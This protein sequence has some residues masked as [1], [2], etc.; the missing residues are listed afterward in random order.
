MYC[1]ACG[2]LNAPNATI[3]VKCGRAMHAVAPAAPAAVPVTTGRVERHIQAMGILWL[4]YALMGAVGWFIAIPFI[5]GFFGMAHHGFPMHHEWPFS[6]MGFPWFVPFVTVLVLLRSGLQLL[7][8]IALLMRAR[9]GRILA[10]VVAILS[11]IKIP[12]GTALGIYTLWVLLPGDAAY[13][14]ERLATH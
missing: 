6:V 9:W 1:S 5:T 2:Q 11:L 4:V 14:Y 13:A 3:C 7:T 10:I 8:G 12:F